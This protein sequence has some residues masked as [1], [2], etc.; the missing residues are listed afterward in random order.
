[1]KMAKTPRHSLGWWVRRGI[2]VG[3]L[4]LL[5]LDS[6][7]ILELVHKKWFVSVTPYSFLLTSYGAASGVLVAVASLARIF[8]SLGKALRWTRRTEPLSTD[9]LLANC[10]R[11]ISGGL[12]RLAFTLPIAIAMGSLLFW[13]GRELQVPPP[14]MLSSRVLVFEKTEK[15]SAQNIPG[16]GE[17]LYVSDDKHG[18]LHVVDSADT[19]EEYRPISIGARGNAGGAHGRPSEMVLDPRNDK[20]YLYVID[21]ADQKVDVVDLNR[22]RSVGSVPTGMAPRSLAV[23]PDGKKLF[24]SN[25]QPVPGG[26]ISVFNIEDPLKISRVK[27][28]GGVNCPEGLAISPN[29]KRV[30][31]ATQCGGDEDPVFVIDTA[32][33]SV[34]ASIP[35]LAVGTSLAVS[36][37]G[38]R[39]YVGRGNFPCQRR[40][41]G[42]GSPFSVVDLPSGKITTVCLRTSVNVVAATRD[43]KYVI[44]A[45]GTYLSVFDAPQIQ[46]RGDDA[47]LKD[48]RLEGG[49]AGIGVDSENNIYA[50]LP[51]TPRLFLYNPNGL[52][53][54]VLRTAGG[55]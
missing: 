36:P 1:V 29:G 46:K 55:S 20:P 39:L 44:V 42:P 7:L 37:D 16:S 47:D 28:I 10:V 35:G 43:G 9:E 15:Y 11:W 23:T 45:N 52:R 4:F 34:I 49:I 22:A 54:P 53:V 19:S 30:Y 2:G 33:D 14:W 6:W 50:W 18:L 25:E 8:Q 38:D 13:L 12:S 3:V 21:D 51:D 31:A 5:T 41:G 32:D 40:A 48:I 26:T 17:L 24:V 27:D